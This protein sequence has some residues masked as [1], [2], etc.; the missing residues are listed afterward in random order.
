MTIFLRL[1]CKFARNRNLNRFHKFVYI[2]MYRF[3]LHIYLSFLIF[4]FQYLSISICLIMSA[5]TSFPLTSHGFSLSSFMLQDLSRLPSISFLPFSLLF[6]DL[7]LC[8]FFLFC[9]IISLFLLTSF[10]LFPFFPFIYHSIKI[11]LCSRISNA[12][13][14]QLSCQLLLGF[15]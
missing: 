1:L 12:S 5:S 8:S 11:L 10:S 6:P 4:L 15:N 2:Y 7:Y 3:F 13:T 9:F 14:Q